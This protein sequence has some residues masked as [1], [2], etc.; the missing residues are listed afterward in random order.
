MAKFLEVSH[1]FNQHD[2]SLGRH[3][4]AA[5]RKNLVYHKT[6]YPFWAKVC[7]NSKY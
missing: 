3:V 5:S 4:N 6:K 1:F 2:S 7:M